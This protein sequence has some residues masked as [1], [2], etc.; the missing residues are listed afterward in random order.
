MIVRNLILHE[1]LLILIHGSSRNH[2]FLLSIAYC[3]LTD[4][5]RW[6]ATNTTFRREQKCFHV[7]VGSARQVVPRK[8]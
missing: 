3:G 1:F 8:G 2:G 4:R 5:M 7:V 6:A